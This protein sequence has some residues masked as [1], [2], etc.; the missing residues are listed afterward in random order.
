[1]FHSILVSIDGSPDSE[2]ALTQAI[3][4]AEGEHAVL[5]LFSAVAG[6]PA[7]A[8]LGGGATTA[9]SLAR[10]AE[11]AARE[12]L[13]DAAERVSGDVSVRTVMSLK[14]VRQALLEEVASGHYDLIV[15]G[16]RGRGAVRAALLGSVSHY[17]LNHSRVPVLVVHAEPGRAAQDANTVPAR[18]TTAEE[19]TVVHAGA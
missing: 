8:Y 4:L 3:D 14:P 1:M 2:L 18:G 17:V 6:P 15:M 16:S 13:R 9:A 11:G 5:T 19:R 12:L 7:M 10:D